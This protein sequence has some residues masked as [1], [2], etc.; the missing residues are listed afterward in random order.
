MSEEYNA[1]NP[2]SK[3]YFALKV[4]VALAVVS[5]II[6]MLWYAMSKPTVLAVDYGIVETNLTLDQASKAT[7]AY[8]KEQGWSGDHSQV[9][10]TR[11]ATSRI[12]HHAKTA[13]SDEIAFELRLT[14][15]GPAASTPALPT[16]V[17]ITKNGD[18]GQLELAKEF[19]AYLKNQF[20]P[21]L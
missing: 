17:Y 4:I 15:P 1:L 7:M 18:S 20:G 2:K 10:V 12:T 5:I 11:D 13:N 19:A 9:V 21:K 8:I 16:T 3:R 14:R 6:L